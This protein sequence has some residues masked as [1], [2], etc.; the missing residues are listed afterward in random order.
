MSAIR[1]EYAVNESVVKYSASIHWPRDLSERIKGWKEKLY[2]NPENQ[3][4][5]FYFSYRK[6]SKTI[7]I[8]SCKNNA[9]VR[10]WLPFTSFPIPAKEAKG[11]FKGLSEC[12]G[13]DPPVVKT[14]TYSILESVPSA[15][16]EVTDNVTAPME[17]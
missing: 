9:A 17:Q 2:A 5:Q 14:P 3:D 10:T 7:R 1:D 12:L 11:K 6:I 8:A 15:N 4:K 13:G 16:C